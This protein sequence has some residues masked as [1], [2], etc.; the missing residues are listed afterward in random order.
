MVEEEFVK[1]SMTPKTS[2]E[3]IQNCP[4]SKGMNCICVRPM[5]GDLYL[6]TFETSEIMEVVLNK[7]LDWLTKTVQTG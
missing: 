1:T 7:Y 6:L 5:G 2:V 4:T 3:E